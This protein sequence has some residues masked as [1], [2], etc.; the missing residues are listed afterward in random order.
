VRM[1][2]FRTVR[3]GATASALAVILC[4]PMFVPAAYAAD[5]TPQQQKMAA[6]SKQNKGKKGDDYKKSQSA[7]L[8]NG[9]EAAAAAPM[10]Q[11]EKMSMC[12]KQNKGKKGDDYK[13]AMS[14]CLKG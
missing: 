5:L 3:R 1:P 10:T 2:M 7:C 12:A 8:T 13:S 9:P 11:Q 14:T 4:A 6:C